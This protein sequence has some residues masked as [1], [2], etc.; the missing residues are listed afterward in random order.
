MLGIRGLSAEVGMD[1]RHSGKGGVLLYV[2]D[3]TNTEIPFTY[4]G[5]SVLSAVAPTSRLIRVTI[6]VADES[7]VQLEF[8]G[9]LPRL[10]NGVVDVVDDYLS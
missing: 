5:K 2:E 7:E 8:G 1:A 6:N 9:G 10:T 4:Q 3:S